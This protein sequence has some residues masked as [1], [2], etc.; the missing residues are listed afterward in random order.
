MTMQDLEGDPGHGPARRPLPRNTATRV[1]QAPDGG[2]EG[3]LGELFEVSAARPVHT[4][5]AAV[6]AFVTGLVAVV[7]APFSLMIGASLG[8]AGLALVSSIVGLARA[9]RID[10]AGT[11]LASLGLVLALGAM[12]ILGLRYAGIDT[13]V[14]DSFVPTLVDW[15]KSLNTLVPAS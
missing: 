14:G 5:A 9:S 1:G 2:I 7:A 8:L 12:A 4:S 6:L 13:A 11:M 10:V 15:L 3:A